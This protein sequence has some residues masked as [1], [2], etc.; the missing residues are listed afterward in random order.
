MNV[1][2]KRIS[3]FAYQIWQSEGEPEGEELAEAESSSSPVHV[4]DSHDGALSIDAADRPD[5]D[6]NGEAAHVP[7][8]GGGGEQLD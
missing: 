6:K 5:R 4:E 1:D 2:E 7:R 3:E 8:P